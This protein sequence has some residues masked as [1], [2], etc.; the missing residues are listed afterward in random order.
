MTI[1]YNIKNTYKDNI[2]KKW[3]SNVSCQGPPNCTPN[4]WGAP[5][6]NK[7]N[8][9]VIHAYN[10]WHVTVFCYRAFYKYFLGLL[11]DPLQAGKNLRWSSDH[12]LKTTVLTYAVFR[13]MN[14]Y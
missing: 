12:R 2:L 11:A 13:K 7:I 1:F 10:I 3:F 5:E 14:H 8:N 4:R 6:P 9:T